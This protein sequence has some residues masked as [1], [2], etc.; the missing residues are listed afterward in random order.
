MRITPLCALPGGGAFAWLE[1]ECSSLCSVRVCR[2]APCTPRGGWGQPWRVQGAWTPKC[3]CNPRAELQAVPRSGGGVG[4]KQG[5]CGG[6]RALPT[7]ARIKT[8]L[9]K[10]TLPPQ[11]TG[12]RGSGGW[13]RQCQ[14]WG[15]DEGGRD[16]KA[17]RGSCGD[18]ARKRKHGERGGIR[19][20][21]RPDCGLGG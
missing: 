6:A 5:A 19:R 7:H 1:R 16:P 10:D 15:T 11:G 13:R 14:Q 21:P 12:R 17:G 9:G 2:R 18:L 4:G 3:A 8:L 20:G